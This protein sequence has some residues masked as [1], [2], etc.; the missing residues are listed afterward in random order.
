MF[1]YE[2]YSCPVCGK[3]FEQSDDIV[4]CPSCGAP[5]HRECWKQEGHCHFESKH[6]TDEQWS[7]ERYVSSQQPVNDTANHYANNNGS[8]PHRQFC[9][10]CG[11]EN[12]QFAEFC[13]RCG[14]ELEAQDWT[15][16]PQQDTRSQESGPYNGGYREYRPFQAPPTVHSTVPDGTD[17]DG[18]PAGQMSQFVAQ[19]TQYYMPR[20]LK[21]AQS[22]SSVSWNWAAFLWTPYWLWYR[23]QYLAGTITLLFQVLTAVTYAFFTYNYLGLGTGFTPMDLSNAWFEL[24]NN[25]ATYPSALRWMT[26]WLLLSLLESLIHIGFGLLGN[27]FYYQLARRRIRRWNQNNSLVPLSS[28]G[29]ISLLLAAAAYFASYFISM[30][31]NLWFI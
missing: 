21:M 12:A 18:I 27:Y 23:K 17:L 25:S 22:G 29:G 10:Q 20:F 13:S 3:A 30:L 6:G 28:I 24:L 11:Q 7:R 5:H 14:H 26:V 9:P 31:I 15:S 8:A 2:G 16:S 4:A 19:N 1:F